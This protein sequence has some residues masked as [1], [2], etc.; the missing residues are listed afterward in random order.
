MNAYLLKI[1]RKTVKTQAITE[2][3][4]KKSQLQDTSV[5]KQECNPPAKSFALVVL[6]KKKEE[7]VSFFFFFNRK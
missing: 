2:C 3:S 5:C 4:G 7:K 6:R 1:M